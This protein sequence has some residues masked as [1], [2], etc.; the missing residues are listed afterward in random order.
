MEY[1]LLRSEQLVGT[2]LI[3]LV[4]ETLAKEVRNVEATTKKVS[5]PITLARLDPDNVSSTVRL[6]SK[7]WRG[8]R[9]P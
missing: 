4:K 3:V 8:T 7:G 5:R 9:E 1:V 6:G 2:A